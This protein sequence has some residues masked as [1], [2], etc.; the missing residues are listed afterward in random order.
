MQVKNLHYIHHSQ[1]RDWIDWTGD[2]RLKKVD[3]LHLGKSLYYID[4]RYIQRYMICFKTYASIISINRVNRLSALCRSQKE[5]HV[6]LRT[7][8]WTF[9]NLSPRICKTHI[10]SK[11]AVYFAMSAIANN[12]KTCVANQQNIQTCKYVNTCIIE[13]GTNHHQFNK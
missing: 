2:W 1:T 8:S 13:H 9:M 12:I 11:F 10:Q 4:P 7:S 3:Q 5:G 6:T